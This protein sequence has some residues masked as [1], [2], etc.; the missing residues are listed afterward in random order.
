MTQTLA[1]VLIDHILYVSSSSPPQLSVITS[2]FPHLNAIVRAYPIPA[3][4]HFNSKL[5]L[6][7]K[8]LKR[9]LS[10]GALESDSKTWPGLP[11][12]SLLRVIPQLWPSSDLNHAVI[13]PT[14]VLMGSYLGLCRVRSLG[15]IASGLFLCTLWLQYE[16]LSKR[17]VPEAV[18]FLLNAVLH[19][20]PHSFKSVESLPGAFPS[21]DFRSDLC[22]PL[23]MAKSKEPADAQT[24]N[25]PELLEA[26]SNDEQ[27]KADLLGLSLNLLGR[28]ANFYKG[29]DGFIELFSPVQ[30]V[31]QS[32]DG[33]K[34]AQKIQV[35]LTHPPKTY[36]LANLYPL[37]KPCHLA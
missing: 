8:N 20:A 26:E 11:E 17:L 14:R 29:L 27:A 31:V 35:C 16:A 3:A 19:I 28:F 6:M 4:R 33:K 13:S 1:N 25:L 36:T 10:K 37:V 30:S 18:N 9:G 12:I 21:P 5:A 2:L 32:V 7:H 22:T 23:R 24:P 15:D 34:L